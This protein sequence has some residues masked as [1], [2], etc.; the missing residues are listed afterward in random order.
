MKISRQSLALSFEKLPLKDRGLIVVIDG[1][2]DPGN[3]GAIIRTSDA[4]GADAVVI[5]PGTCNTFMAKVIRSTAGSI[6][7]VPVV[8]TT[9]DEFLGW[10]LQKKIKL[11]VASVDAE[12]SVHETDLNV[13]LAL[14]F[15]NEAHGV[16]KKLR[17]SADMFLKIPMPGKA[18]SLN[19]AISAAIC[20]YEA[21]RQ[22]NLS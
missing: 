3:L 12:R 2:Q 15:G 22:R 9:P 17:E 11:I 14:A 13:P 8:H 20:L 16:S 19:V 5:L 18:E 7:N 4:S 10:I 21:V 6:F 1:I